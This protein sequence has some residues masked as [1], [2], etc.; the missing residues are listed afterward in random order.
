MRG[1]PLIRYDAETRATAAGLAGVVDVADVLAVWEAA[2]AAPYTGRPVWVHGDM[3][4]SNLLVEEGRLAGLIDFGS[5]A[6]GDPACDLVLAWT[7]LHGEGRAAFR[8]GVPADEAGSARAHGW[9]IWKALL[10]VAQGADAPAAEQRYGWRCPSMELI[11]ELV[12]E[13]AAAEKRA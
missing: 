7:L 11:T 3:T 10:T 2:I 9:A 13:H 1:G 6:V 4:G 5:S 8:A 12:T